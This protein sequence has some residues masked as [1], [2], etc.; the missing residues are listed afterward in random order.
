MLYPFL[1]MLEQ[2][3]SNP[4]LDSTRNRD[5]QDMIGGLLQV[6]LVQIGSTVDKEMSDK[7]V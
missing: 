3:L 6:V 7:I 1:G 5:T 2:T 4:D